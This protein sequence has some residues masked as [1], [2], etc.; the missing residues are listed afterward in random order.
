MWTL[1]GGKK[2]PLVLN[3]INEIIPKH[4]VNQKL[5]VDDGSKDNTVSIAENMVGML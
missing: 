3:R 4:I 1:N 2:L 5:I